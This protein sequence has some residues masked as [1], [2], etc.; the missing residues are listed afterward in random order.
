MNLIWHIIKKDFSHNRLVIF[1]WAASGI[2]VELSTT[3]FVRGTWTE[4]GY[5]IVCLL[6]C[7]VLPVGLIASIYQEDHMVDSDGFLRTRPISPCRLLAAKLGLVWTL[8]VIA[9]LLLLLIE[10]MVTPVTSRAPGLGTIGLNL[11]FVVLVLSAV[12]AWCKNLSRYFLALLTGIFFFGLSRIAFSSLIEAT[13][14]GLRALLRQ[15]NSALM[16]VVFSGF[17]AA[18]LYNIYYRRRLL[19]A[20]SLMVI[21]LIGTTLMGDFLTTPLP[22]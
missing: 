18:A 19:V 11:T 22:R 1:W 9:P 15:T 4:H 16:T 17:W 10:R 2:L 20:I 13:P 8:F 21:G 5:L 7:Y 14:L 12:A 6:A 3:D